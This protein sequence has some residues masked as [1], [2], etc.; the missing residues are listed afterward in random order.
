MSA[1][2]LAPDAAPLVTTV[3]AKGQVVLPKA[4]RTRRD[5]PS[6]T[7]LI[8]EETPDGVLLRPAA[9]FPATQLDAVFGCLAHD[10]PPLSPAQMDAAVAAEARRR[11]RD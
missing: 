4:V 5:W 9:A 8:V 6:G 1:P 11:A 7:R 3:S 2:D 10:G